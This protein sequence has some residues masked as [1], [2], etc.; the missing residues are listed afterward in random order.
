MKHFHASSARVLNKQ[1]NLEGRTVW[2]QYW[3]TQ[4]TIQGSYLARLNYVMNNPVRHG[5][6][7]DAKEYPWCSANWFAKNAKKS[8]YKTVQNMKTDKV[9]VVDDF[10]LEKN[11]ECGDLS[12]LC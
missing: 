12:P 7:N 3:D 9:Q 1:Y 10:N 5:L 2:Y 8:H 6:V 11:L 4:I